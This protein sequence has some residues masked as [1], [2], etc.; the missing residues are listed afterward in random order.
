MK[1]ADTG[2]LG[3]QYSTSEKLAARARLHQNYT[4]SEMGWFEWV[5]A[6]L[7]LK[8]GSAI[9]DI[10]CGPGWFWASAATD[11]PDRIDLTLA[12]ASPGMVAE[13]LGRCTPLRHWQVSGREADASAMPFADDRFDLVL[14]MHMLYHVPDAAKA[15]AEMWRVL[16]PG[17]TLAVTTNGAA[18]LRELYALSAVFGSPPTEPV[19]AIFGFDHAEQLMRTQFGNVH[20]EVQP[21][22]LRAT[23]PE[24]VFMALTSYP[25][26]EGAPEAQLREFRERIAEAFAAGGGAL[27][28]KKETALFLSRKA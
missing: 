16:R 11:L 15:I 12:D 20:I 9:L 3:R 7:P 10:G 1:L 6:R 5:A 28:T 19:A 8:A 25:P 2:E 21:A 13:A 26:G 23:D 22:H 18:N 27:V 24:T 17:G 14:A 4:V